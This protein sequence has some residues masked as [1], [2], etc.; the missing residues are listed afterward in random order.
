MKIKKRN[1]FVKVFILLCICIIFMKYDGK[2]VQAANQKAVSAYKNFLKSHYQ[3]KY[4]AIV[5]AGKKKA[6]VLMIADSNFEGTTSAA[7]TPQYGYPIYL[8]NYVNGKVKKISGQISQRMSAGPWFLYKNKISAFNARGGYTYLSISGKNYK[9]KFVNKDLGGKIKTITLKK[10]TYR[11]FAA[12]K[13]SSW[14]KTHDSATCNCKIPHDGV[15]YTISW[16]KVKGA[17]GYQI[18]SYFKEQGSDSWYLEKKTQT[19]RTYTNNCSHINFDLKIK[20]RAYKIVDGK[21]AYGKW[22]SYKTK[23]VRF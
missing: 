4:Y 11:L 18:Y 19:K 20:V 21:K 13:L 9:R 3:N 8:Y 7:Y 15:A 17:A 10:N 1:V 5:Y 23:S 12:P 6:P 16:K 2:E 14:K 22:S